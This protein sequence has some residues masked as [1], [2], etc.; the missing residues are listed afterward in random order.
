M[1]LK[2]L[3]EENVA[4][5]ATDKINIIKDGQSSKETYYGHIHTY[6][7]YISFLKLNKM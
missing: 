7:L 2:K 5:D 3:L 6:S 1:L 4:L